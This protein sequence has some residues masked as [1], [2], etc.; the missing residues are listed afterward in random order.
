M[1]VSLTTELLVTPPLST[2]NFNLDLYWVLTSKSSIKKQVPPENTLDER[3]G[4]LPMLIL[5]EM[6]SYTIHFLEMFTEKGGNIYI[7]T[8]FKKLISTGTIVCSQPT[9]AIN[10]SRFPS[11]TAYVL[12]A[13]SSQP[14]GVLSGQLLKISA[15][16]LPDHEFP[17][18][19]WTNWQPS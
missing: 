2:V 8:I 5:Y 13:P 4:L 1:H 9:P 19:K 14:I 15:L 12:R 6:C 11:V 16:E 3:L 18:L 7:K 10:F 17:Q